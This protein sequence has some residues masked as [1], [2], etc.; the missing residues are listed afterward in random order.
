MI[1]LTFFAYH[2][3]S[4]LKYFFIKHWVKVY[5][6]LQNTNAILNL[7]SLD[8]E[9][10][11]RSGDSDLLNDFYIPC[12][13]NS[14]IYKRA[15]GFFTSA[16]LAE[17]ARGLESFVKNDGILQIIASPKLTEKDEKDIESG[18][19][20]REVIEKALKR[21]LEI[22]LSPDDAIK[23]KNLSWMISNNKLDIKIA[24]PTSLSGEGIYH[25]KI[26]LFFDSIN[27]IESNIVAFSGSLNE[28]SQGLMS[29][30]ESIDVS[31]SWDKGIRETGR[32][33]NH[34]N[35]F[36]SMWNGNAKG[37]EVFD[38]PEAIQKKMIEIYPPAYPKNRIS[39]EKKLYS[40]QETAI[41]K[42]IEADQKGVLAMATGSGKTF[43]A[44][45]CLESCSKPLITVIIV[46]YIDLVH[47]WKKEITKQYPD[48]CRIRVAYSEE[49]DWETKIQNLVNGFMQDSKMNFIVT[50]I[51]TASGDKLKSI[52][53]KIPKEN[54]AIVIDEVHH[55]G[56]PEFSKV[57]GINAKYRLGLSATPERM[58]DDQGNQLIFD[59]F[60][61]TVYEYDIESAIK[62]KVLCQYHYFI[63]P[64]ALTQD[65]REN[66][67]I[68]TQKIIKLTS[69]ARNKYPHLK[70]KNT[71]EVLLYLLQNRNSLGYTLQ[72]LFLKRIEILKKAVSKKDAL[73][74]IIRNS[75]LKRCLIYCNDLQHL[76]EFKKILFDEGCDS[77]KYSSEIDPLQRKKIIEDFCNELN[78]KQF[79][80]AVKCLDEGVDL[81]ACDSAILVSSSRSTREFI[82]RRGRI[83]RKHHS[84]EFSIIHD[85]II[86]PFTTMDDAYN[87][88]ESEEDFIKNEL[89]RINQFAQNAINKD[90]ILQEISH[91][92]RLFN[93]SDQ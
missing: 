28:T 71:I 64:V 42:W 23:V 46:P 45:N 88:T 81:P 70:T 24:K 78:G 85:I 15:V 87:L 25:E 32:V 65:E 43:T 36:N 29:N 83:L 58:W 53:S 30:Y 14:I 79:L 10:T 62:D 52:I 69:V 18:Y 47:Q 55:S 9:V 67:Q 20:E 57:F 12:L 50:T 26:G 51:Q 40:F 1:F 77:K 21:G 7:R 33:K 66:F 93:L 8:L 72:N 60:G 91:I 27:E 17:A 80:V 86:L 73:R 54:L 92:N 82:Q 39:I 22:N 2:S 90:K 68:I 11:Y 16:S 56:S 6:N 35:H 19:N 74:K 59:Y 41:K 3:F 5:I 76:D 44:L 89:D 31:L 34:V 61:P 4:I 75:D 13:E 38:F 48:N 49:K 63:H 37:L 84:K